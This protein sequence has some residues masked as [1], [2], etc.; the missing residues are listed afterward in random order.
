MG[1]EGARAPRRILLGFTFNLDRP[2]ITLPGEK[3]AGAR[4]LPNSLLEMKGSQ[5]V[6][7]AEVQ[8]LRGHLE[9]PQTTN[10]VWKLANG[11]DDSLLGFPDDQGLYARRP[12]PTVWEMCWASM[13]LIE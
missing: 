2:T 12:N 13:E 9:H 1:E 7:T 3:I 5:L 4:V 11:P 10:E 6:T 8:Q